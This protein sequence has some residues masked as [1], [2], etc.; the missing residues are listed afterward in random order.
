MMMIPLTGAF[1]KMM[2]T[3]DPGPPLTRRRT[4]RWIFQLLAR[5]RMGKAIIQQ[6]SDK[7]LNDEE[8]ST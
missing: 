6:I 3:P 7:L 1:R 8:E 2:P 4:I 5:E